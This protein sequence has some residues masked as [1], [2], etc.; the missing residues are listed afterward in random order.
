MPRHS[1][2]AKVAKIKVTPDNRMTLPKP[3][4]DALPWLVGKSETDAW[5]Y[6]VEPGRYRLLSDEDIENDPDL[7]PVRAA[8]LQEKPDVRALPS[9]AT[10]MRDAAMPIRLVPIT[11]ELH[12]GSYRTPY[13]EELAVLAPRYC[14][15]RDLSI[16][17]PEGYLE[18]W[19]TDALLRATDRSWRNS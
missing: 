18:I 16:L 4:C 2:S 19:Y 1:P 7:Q 3:F 9:H 13:V 11:I 12:K 17:M 5:L 10:E 15:P 8:M 14:D 6:L